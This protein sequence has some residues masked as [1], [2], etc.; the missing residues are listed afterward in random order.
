[1]KAK[2]GAN[3]CTLQWQKYNIQIF[4]FYE[5]RFSE[6]LNDE[7]NSIAVES[8]IPLKSSPFVHKHAS[9]VVGWVFQESKNK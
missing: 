6:N 7:H 8:L 9:F 2:I 3:I 4:S 1:M 5:L